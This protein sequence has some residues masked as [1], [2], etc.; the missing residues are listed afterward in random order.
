V[1]FA[2]LNYRLSA[3]PSYPQPSPQPQPQPPLPTSSDQET[4]AKAPTPETKYRNA[5]HPDHIQDI[6]SGIHL[7]QQKYGFTENYI[8]VGHSAGATLAFQA[9][10]ADLLLIPPP[11]P[12]LGI[13]SGLRGNEA[14]RDGVAP[15]ST[16]TSTSILAPIVPPKA[17]IGVS[18]IY[19]LRRLYLDYA[20]IPVY[21]EI[22]VGAFSED[23]QLSGGGFNSYEKESTT[24]WSEDRTYWDTVSPAHGPT[25]IQPGTRVKVVPSSSD[26][27]SGSGSPVY[28]DG[29]SIARGWTNGRLVVIAS[30]VNDG[31]VNDAQ[32]DIMTASLENGWKTEGQVVRRKRR[33]VIRLADLQQ[34]HDDIWK[35]GDELARV[36]AVGLD[37][38]ISLS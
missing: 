17:I 13:N 4:G 12:Q 34:E 11:P 27:G 1:A 24:E 37:K 38:L 36:I 22:L 7:L 29:E 21:G 8:L 32:H 26:S 20:H 31:L 14:S 15:I 6:T 33:E 9:V 18:G 3:H 10:M 2:S 19:D 28:K 30:S 25:S 16:S 35:N 5:K 23:Y